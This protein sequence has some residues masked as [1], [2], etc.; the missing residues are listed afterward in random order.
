MRAAPGQPQPLRASRRPAS[1]VLA[2]PD[3]SANGQRVIEGE[4]VEGRE[5]QPDRRLL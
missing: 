5:V 3:G 4:E 2:L 1:A